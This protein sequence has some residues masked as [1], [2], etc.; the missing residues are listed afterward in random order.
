MKAYDPFYSTKLVQWKWDS[1]YN[2]NILYEYDKKITPVILDQDEVKGLPRE[3]ENKYV[4]KITGE[5]LLMF[6]IDG[7][8]NIDSIE[9]MYDKKM[10]LIRGWVAL[11]DRD[12]SDE[13]CKKRLLLKSVSN[14]NVIYSMEIIPKQ[15]FDVASLFDDKT[16]NA[17]NSGINVFFEEETIPEGKYI[18]GV[19]IENNR[20]FVKWSTETIER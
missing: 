14:E 17:S 11:R 6:N 1:E 15:R 3:H 20:R 13:K 9:N 10:I 7:I 5:N 12:N 4:K 8:D 18:V 16:K 19:L 2:E